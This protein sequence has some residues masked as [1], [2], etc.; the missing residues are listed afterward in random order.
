MRK[1]D[2]DMGF[3]GKVPVFIITILVFIMGSRIGSDETIVR[4]LDTIGLTALGLTLFMMA[5][6]VAAV[7][8]L[9]KGMGFDKEGRRKISADMTGEPGMHTSSE[10][11]ENIPADPGADT[12]A[13]EE[14]GQEP[15]REMVMLI[16]P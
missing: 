14:T 8:T 11:N 13:C 10:Q 5:G 1:N 9:R 15:E 16:I 2:R 7:F 3:A 4:S 6:S 12:A